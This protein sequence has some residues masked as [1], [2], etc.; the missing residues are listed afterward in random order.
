[1]FRHGFKALYSWELADHIVFAS[2]LWDQENDH[3]KEKKLF[4][5]FLLFFRVQSYFHRNLI[6]KS[7]L[8]LYPS[9]NDKFAGKQFLLFHSAATYTYQKM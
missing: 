3:T 4:Q 5:G 7:N 1:M 9:L 2:A 8:T 6:I